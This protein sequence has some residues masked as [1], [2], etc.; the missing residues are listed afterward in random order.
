MNMTEYEIHETMM[1]V[2]IAIPPTPNGNENEKFSRA[3]SFEPQNSNQKYVRWPPTWL[4]F[5][6]KGFT[7]LPKPFSVKP[8]NVVPL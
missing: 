1:N 3:T 7:S 6:K 5:Q 4:G 8:L 2:K